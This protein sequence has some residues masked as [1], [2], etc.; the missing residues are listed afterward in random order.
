MCSARLANWFY[1]L[2]QHNAPRQKVNATKSFMG[3]L[4]GYPERSEG[5]QSGNDV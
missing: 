2:G 4:N 3:S 1:W 5:F